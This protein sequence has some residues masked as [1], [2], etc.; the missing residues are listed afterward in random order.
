MTALSAIGK[1]RRSLHDGL[2]AAAT[3]PL[4]LGYHT[5]SL[6]RFPKKLALA[7]VEKL[8]GAHAIHTQTGV[9]FIPLVRTSLKVSKMAHQTDPG[10]PWFGYLACGKL[11]FS[12]PQNTKYPIW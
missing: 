7:G 11:A 8:I 10:M 1:L 2:C 4:C 6:S 3:L 5:L 12:C 9:T